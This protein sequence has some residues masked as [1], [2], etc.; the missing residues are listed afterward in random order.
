[1]KFLSICEIKIVKSSKAWIREIQYFVLYVYSIN[2]NSFRLL[3]FNSLQ[4]FG[5]VNAL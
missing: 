1:M 4:I 2:F 3:K 5:L